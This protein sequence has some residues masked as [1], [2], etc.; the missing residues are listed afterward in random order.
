MLDLP[1][2]PYR[3]PLRR[4]AR[5][6]PHVLMLMGWGSEQTRVTAFLLHHAVW[7]RQPAGQQPPRADRA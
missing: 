6:R 4:R 1:R 2:K 7:A 5:P 3:N